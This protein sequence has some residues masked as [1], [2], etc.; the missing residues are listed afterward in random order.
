MLAFKPKNNEILDGVVHNVNKD[1]IEVFS[2]PIKCFIKVDVSFVL[3]LIIF[4]ENGRWVWIWL[5]SRSIYFSKVRIP[6]NKKNHGNQTQ[7][8]DIEVWKKWILCNQL[9][10]R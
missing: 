10:F 4:A 8:W 1:G 7:D 5:N 9:N 3:F 2:G 6:A